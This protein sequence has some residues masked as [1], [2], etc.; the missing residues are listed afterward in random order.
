MKAMASRTLSRPRDRSGGRPA[1]VGLERSPGLIQR[2]Q[3]TGAKPPAPVAQPVPPP[4]KRAC[5][6]FDDGPYLGT[7]DVLDALG[8]RPATFFLNGQNI[9]KESKNFL[10]GE[11]QQK[12]LV[13]RILGAGHR[14]GNHTLEHMP[15]KGSEYE[16][17]YRNLTDAQ[18]LAKLQQA[19]DTN[20]EHFERVMGG[21]V[22]GLREMARLPGQGKFMNFGGKER[23]VKLT[24][25]LGMAHVGWQFEFASDGEMTHLP[26]HDWQ[27]IPRVDATAAGLPNANDI[28][29]LHDRNWLGKSLLLK[30]VLTKLETNNF[31]FGH[32]S[33]EGTCS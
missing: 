8:T 14:L 18:R 19:Y 7:T 27:R 26:A 28:L 2:Q 15:T 4:A 30:E 32:L 3:P 17:A 25:G 20:L 5:L 10:V 29:L 33:K 21:P 1:R 31:T 24:Q 12:N 9:E 16:K 22:P 13:E 6:T 23:L 11:D